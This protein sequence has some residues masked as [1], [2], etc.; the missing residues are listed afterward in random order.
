M[1]Y[2]ISLRLGGSLVHICG[3][4]FSG[5][6]SSLEASDRCTCLEADAVP[7]ASPGIP[8]SLESVSRNLAAAVCAADAHC[9]VNTALYSQPSLTWSTR[10]TSL[11]LNVRSARGL[12]PKSS[13]HSKWV[14]FLRKYV[15]RRL[16]ALSE[17][18]IAAL[19]TSMQQIGEYP[20]RR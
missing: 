9:S 4:S 13:A 1:S 7:L 6:G 18:D 12:S 17:G 8:W 3:H 20:R 10:S 5:S 2:C 15:S 14:S 16:L 19:T 11:P